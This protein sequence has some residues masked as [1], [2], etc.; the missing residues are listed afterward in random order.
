MV[1]KYQ[2]IELTWLL[3]KLKEAGLR[4]GANKLMDIL[5]EQVECMYFKNLGP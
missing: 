4:I 5:D 3:N 2:P 1:L